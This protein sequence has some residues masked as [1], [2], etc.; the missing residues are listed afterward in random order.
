[1]SY[2]T[3]ILPFTVYDREAEL[4]L[5]T[6][7]L[8]KAGVQ[9]VLNLIK[10]RGE[11][12]LKTSLIRF[13]AKYYREAYKLI[14]NKYYAESCCEL[15]YEIGKSYLSLREYWG[16]KLGRKLPVELQDIELSDWIMFESRGDR[17]AKGNPNIRLL[18]LE[19]VK[20]KVFGVDKRSYS[21]ELWVG[22][23]KSRRFRCIL[24]ELIG[25]A[26]SR[27]VGYNARVYIRDASENAVKGDV[28]VAVPFTVY[29]KYYSTLFSENYNP[30]YV[31]G[32]DVNYDRV[33][34]VL[35]N[36]N[37]EVR[38]METLDLTKYVTHGRRWKDARAYTIQWLHKLFNGI[39]ME[40]GEFMVSVEDP[41]VLGMLKLKWIVL[42]GRKH[43]DYNCRV[44]RFTSSLSEAILDTAG[45]LGVRTVKVDPKG[46]TS[47]REHEYFMRKCGL[48]K[49]MASAYMIALRGL[50]TIT[51]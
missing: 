40:Y 27:Q 13:K 22:K 28:Q 21:I 20:V 24:E 44:A 37:G 19:H 30:K 31:L 38:Y 26:N 7:S 1:V 2:R 41:E 10:E 14:P 6:A 16:R 8:W 39:A 18:D 50:K 43:S 17:Y 4:L 33:N 9:H 11:H 15:V 35:V 12:E 32:F 48:D 42:G 29:S 46:T 34:A 47:S 23:P 36:L 49:H 25:L 5:Y 3:I 51:P 45:K